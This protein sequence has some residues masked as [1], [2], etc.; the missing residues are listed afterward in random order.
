LTVAIDDVPGTS[1]PS[2]TLDDGERKAV[3]TASATSDEYFVDVTADGR[4]SPNFVVQRR[5]LPTPPKGS[6]LRLQGP[7]EW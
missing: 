2:A 5:S 3:V 7:I 6:W 1:G 4:T